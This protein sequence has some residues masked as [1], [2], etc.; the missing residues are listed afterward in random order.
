MDEA[1]LHEVVVVYIGGKPFAFPIDSVR[2]VLPMLEPTPMPNWPDNILGII[3]IRGDLV[4]LVEINQLL[5]LPPMKVSTKQ[6]V[7]VVWVLD[8]LWGFV[9][10]SVEGVR[11]TPI[12]QVDKIAPGVL[13]TSAL[14]AGLLADPGASIVLLAPLQVVQALKI[15]IEPID[16]LGTHG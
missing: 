11:N 9:V 4:P 1:E 5:G 15:P 13:Q 10:D 8:R 14:C 12:R 16:Q 2:E 3:E 7:L 6:F